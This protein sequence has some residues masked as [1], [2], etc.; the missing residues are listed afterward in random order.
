MAPDRPKREEGWLEALE[1]KARRLFAG[2]AERHGIEW[3]WDPG[4]PVEV[5]ALYPR[6][7][8]LDF[9]LWLT[10]QG[11]EI[12]LGGDDWR[13]VS[14]PADDPENWALIESVLDGL[15]AGTARVRLYSSP[16]RTK[17]YSTEV[18]LPK[19]EGWESVSTGLGCALLPFARVTILQNGR[20]A[21]REPGRVP[22]WGC[23]AALAALAGFVWWLLG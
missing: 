15:I 10:L 7:P 12:V 5:A 18:Q 16:L 23:I 19:G 1:E 20:G 11:D 4:S 17:P 22:A 6:Q 21:R 13:F 3:R 14:F 9:E 8:G 2:A